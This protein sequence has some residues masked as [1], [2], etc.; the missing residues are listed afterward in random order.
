MVD[1]WEDMTEEERFEA[2]RQALKHLGDTTGATIENLVDRVK[3]LE[4]EVAKLKER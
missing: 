4:T 1:R 3:A 2:P